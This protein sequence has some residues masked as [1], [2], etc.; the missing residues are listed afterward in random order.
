[1]SINQKLCKLRHEHHK[2]PVTALEFLS[3]KTLLVGEGTKLVAYSVSHKHRLGSTKV[4][5]SQAIHKILVHQPSQT[6]LVYGGSY[7]AF[8]RTE[9][10]ERG[11][12]EFTVLGQEN[13]GDWIFDASF[14]P[15]PEGLAVAQ[16]AIVTAHNALIKCTPSLRSERSN[17]VGIATETL[18]PGSNCILYCAHISWLS[19]SRCL[20]AS[21]TAFGDII[22]WSS[23][24]DATDGKRTIPKTHYIFQAH[25][26]SVF[27][28][29]VSPS[30]QESTVRGPTRM[31]A[32]CSDDRTVRLWDITDLD[33]SC[34]SLTE[35]QRETGF[36]STD[37]SN[38]Y[39]PPLL[40][41]AM[42]HISRIWEVKFAYGE[43][44]DMKDQSGSLPSA[45]VSFGEDCSR[46]TWEVKCTTDEAGHTTYE[47]LQAHV[48][49]LHAGKN[50]WSTAM[51]GA[52]CAS[53]GADG[54][55]AMSSSVE[56]GPEISSIDG[57]LVD[58]V[59]E[60][61][62]IASEDG[63][64]S[65]AFVNDKHTHNTLVATT[66]Q[67]RIVAMTL[68]WDQKWSL[69][70]YGTHQHLSSFSTVVGSVDV[71]FIAGVGGSI[72]MYSLRA[73]QCLSIAQASGKV[74][75][76]FVSE[77][78]IDGLDL[79]FEPDRHSVLVT[80]V[81][82]NVAQLLEVK[83]LD[84]RPHPVQYTTKATALELQPGFIVTSFSLIECGN[85]KCAVLGSR[86]GSMAFYYLAETSS[87]Q[88]FGTTQ[89]LLNSHGKESITAMRWNYNGSADDPSGFLFSTGRDGTC[90]IHRVICRNAA[91]SLELVH[92]LELPF[93][94]N[95]EGFTFT[96]DEMC[97]LVV[98]G[99]GGK[100]FISHNVTTQQDI[101]TVQ[102]GGGVNRNWAYQP[103]EN[104]GA[105]TWTQNSKLVRTMQTVPPQQ[106]IHHGGHGREIKAVAVSS[107]EHQIIATGSE[108]TDIKLFSYDHQGGFQCLQT[109][110]KHNTGIQHLQWSADGRY[111]FSSG[112]SEEFY[113][114]RVHHDLPFL[115]IGVVCESSHPRSRT[116]DLRITSFDVSK[117]VSGDGEGG[118]AIFDITMGYSDSSVKRWCYEKGT[119]TLRAS[120]DYLTA[121]LT[122]V[123]R[124]PAIKGT[125]HDSRL[126][127]TATDGY[128]L[129][130]EP[131]TSGQLTWS[132]RH[133]VH[134]NA[135]L[136]V[137]THR[138]TDG[139]TLFIT[140]GDDNGIGFSRILANS[141]TATLLIPRAHAAA[142]TA[143]AI[144]P[145]GEDCFHILSA[146][147][148]QRV[149]LWNVR[150]DVTAHGAA[151]LQIGKAQ[152]VYTSVADV[153]SMS[154]LQLRD[155]STGILI[156]GVGMDLWSLEDLSQ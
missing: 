69:V 74:A 154:L 62:C 41:R 47:L 86:K 21:G 98:W 122:N 128:T 38:S 147:I 73:K 35:I 155:R 93:G 3:S 26:G 57:N 59:S 36:G 95:I 18:V 99:F 139:S 121:C 141:E 54:S 127:T 119:W 89:I 134:Q 80:T 45:L 75:G 84:C 27:G 24:F 151:S 30:G 6:I 148:D 66:S 65:Y 83:E 112:G 152:N 12:Y 118:E 58:L 136:D 15:L 10:T 132:Q 49:S 131:G 85:T 81:G 100:N 96:D 125:T 33:C 109:I 53:G 71:T 138:L 39:A 92:Q 70:S 25:D 7:I 28:V 101:F 5:R 156:C 34:P 120:G 143:L 142:V 102:C 40:A 64:R 140:A 130:W 29:Q 145:S 67:G 124:L 106:N 114:W 123:K 48:H 149:K 55:I 104:G 37:E 68:G 90:A 43:F 9:E 44:S 82:S 97:D 87:H 153:S 105:F 115:R 111:L 150:V 17:Q 56:R 144:H 1:M 126:I 61:T 117:Q 31:L 129:C 91:L 23:A 4:F 16:V 13:V 113:V 116:S 60:G 46:I 77:S 51:N 72:L 76:M 14:S 88:V 78:L 8:V 32:S 137:S 107:G 19:D 11:L 79:E 108:D 63:F 133:K 2:L 50:I 110:R 52:D 94:P 146:S 42:G 135:V 103:S 22:L 20:V